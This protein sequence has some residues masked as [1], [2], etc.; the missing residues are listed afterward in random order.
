M[1][2]IV[3]TLLVSQVFKVPLDDVFQYPSSDEVQP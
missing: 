2:L 1:I 3:A